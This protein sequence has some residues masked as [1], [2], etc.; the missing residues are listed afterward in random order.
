[1]HCSPEA[2]LAVFFVFPPPPPPVCSAVFI[3]VQFTTDDNN[4]PG[5]LPLRLALPFSR[6]CHAKRRRCTTE[7]IFSFVA[8]KKISIDFISPTLTLPLSTPCRSIP[9]PRPVCY[10]AAIHRPAADTKTAAQRCSI[11]SLVRRPIPVT[12]P[13]VR[14]RII[15]SSARTDP[16][17]ARAPV[18]S[19]LPSPCKVQHYR[20]IVPAAPSMAR[21]RR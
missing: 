4:R 13:G 2:S 17:R 6:P 5:G 21:T 18:Q 11:S 20:L 15:I 16:P 19:L 1:M 9:S 3:R 8:R 7:P 12:R 14:S 10:F